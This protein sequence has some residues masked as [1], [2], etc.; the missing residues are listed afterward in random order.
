MVGSLSAQQW[1][2]YSSYR[3]FRVGATPACAITYP[4]HRYEPI[5]RQRSIRNVGKAIHPSYVEGQNPGRC[6]VG[7]RLGA[8]RGVHLRLEGEDG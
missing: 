1:R 8:E 7:H 5:L 2:I 4:M 3:I 6:G